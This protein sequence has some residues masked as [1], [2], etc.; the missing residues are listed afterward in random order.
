MRHAE[1]TQADAMRE[2]I[3]K[4]DKQ[5]AG[6]T[7]TLGDPN[8]PASVRQDFV[9]NYDRA[10]QEK[11]HLEAELESQEAMAEHVRAVL[12]PAQVLE[13]LKHSTKFCRAIT[14]RWRTWSWHAISSTSIATTMETSFSGALSLGSSRAAWNCSAAIKTCNSLHRLNLTRHLSPR[15]SRDA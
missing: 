15:W 1:P 11:G 5:L 8:L 7:M 10:K 4:I 2:K 14:L 12:D 6:W 3:Q 9:L 13:S